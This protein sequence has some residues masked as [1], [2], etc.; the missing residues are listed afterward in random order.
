[1]L[2]DADTVYSTTADGIVYVINANFTTARSAT[3]GSAS[4]NGTVS[5]WYIAC[6]SG[7]TFVRAFFYFPLTDLSGNV[8][9]ASQF[10]YGATARTLSSNCIMKGTQA[11]TLV[12]GDYDSFSGDSYGYV[13]WNGAAYN[14]IVFNAQGCSDVQ[15]ALGLTFK[16]CSREYEHDYLNSSSGLGANA[17]KN[18]CYLAD[19]TGFDKDPKMS[20]T[21][22]A[23]TKAPIVRPNP[24]R[25]MLVR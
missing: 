25:H 8:T 3:S 21:T 24:M 11:D 10:I 1:L 7:Y 2:V 23:A 20:I 12:G 19:N 15:A 16:T 13:A 22:V 6:Y 18:G 14:E 5:D 4:N 17:F 9:A